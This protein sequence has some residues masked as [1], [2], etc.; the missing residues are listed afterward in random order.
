M[1]SAAVQLKP[2]S[3]LFASSSSAMPASARWAD[4]VDE[5]E[6]V[7]VSGSFGAV[8][9]SPIGAEEKGG[10]AAL[11]SSAFCADETGAFCAV[12]NKNEKI[13]KEETHAHKKRRIFELTRIHITNTDS[14]LTNT[15]LVGEQSTAAYLKYKVSKRQKVP[16]ENLTLLWKGRVLKDHE[17][18]KKKHADKRQEPS[19]LDRQEENDSSLGAERTF[20]NANGGPPES[21]DQGLYGESC[22]ENRH[23]SRKT[24]THIRKVEVHG[25]MAD[26][27][28]QHTRRHFR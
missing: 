22:E 6:A 9:S 25:F 26:R 10:C 5:D 17:V 4:M 28:L 24:Q 7:G 2:C 16:L 8:I 19:T 3:A 18:F 23:T 11:F 13:S 20:Y 12:E 15:I 27:R 21:L 1:L 14:N